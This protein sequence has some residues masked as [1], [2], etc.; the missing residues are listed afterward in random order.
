MYAIFKLFAISFMKFKFK[1]LDMPFKM[2]YSANVDVKRRFP[3]FFVTRWTV[4]DIFQRIFPPWLYNIHWFFAYLPRWKANFAVFSKIISLMIGK[5]D[6]LF[7]NF[8]LG[9]TIFNQYS[10]YCHSARKSYLY[11][12]SIEVSSTADFFLRIALSKVQHATSKR[13]KKIKMLSVFSAHFV[14]HHSSLFCLP[15]DEKKFFQIITALLRSKVYVSQ[16]TCVHVE[17]LGFMSWALWSRFLLL[18]LSISFTTCDNLYSK[19]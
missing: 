7:V 6:L 16:V 8:F 10:F 19:K 17:A 9:Y 11:Y 15:C 13:W 18:L 4:I 3:I 14:E 2:A 12:K 1:S 5:K